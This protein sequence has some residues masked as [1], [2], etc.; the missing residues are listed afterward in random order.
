MRPIDRVF[1]GKA[2]RRF[3]PSPSRPGV[4]YMAT[5]FG[6]LQVDLCARL[7]DHCIR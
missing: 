6:I 3:N 1:V 2:A 7:P 4:G 5:S